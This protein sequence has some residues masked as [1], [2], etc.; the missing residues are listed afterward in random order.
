MWRGYCG[1]GS[2]A[3]IVFDTGKLQVRDESSL[4]IAN[5]RHGTAK[6]RMEWL[7]QRIP[8]FAGIVAKSN[9]DDDQLW[10]A[11]YYF[12]SDLSC[13]LFSR[14]IAVSEKKMSGG[15]FTCRP[16]YQQSF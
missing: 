6:E 5:V 2:G 3:A 8:E 1:N 4:I 10:L 7:R 15:W 11:A 14:N 12:P 16:V 13:S 9:I